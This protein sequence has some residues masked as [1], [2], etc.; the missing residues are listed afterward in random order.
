MRAAYVYEKARILNRRFA[1]LGGLLCLSIVGNTAMAISVATQSKVVL[2][3]TLVD[4]VEVSGAGVDRDYLERLARDAAYT[5]LNRTPETARYF[6]R[7][8]E[9]IASPDTY[10]EIKSALIADRQQ[11]QNS[12][13]SQVFYPMDFWV[14]PGKLYVEA[15]GDVLTMNNREVVD[16]ERKT[17]ALTF[18]RQGSMILL[19]SFVPITKDEANGTRARAANTDEAL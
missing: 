10:H 15:T 19:K 1:V 6:E 9:R 7:N 3:P 17:F 11:R 12:R 4:T 8:L 16:S 5:F 13:T 14:D 18:E 2:V